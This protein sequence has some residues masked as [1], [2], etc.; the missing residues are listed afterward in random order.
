MENPKK[1]LLFP[2]D[3]ALIIWFCVTLA[4]TIA[5]SVVNAICHGIKFEFFEVVGNWIAV[6]LLFFI[7]S[8]TAKIIG[9]CYAESKEKKERFILIFF[10]FFHSLLILYDMSLFTPLFEY[11]T[12]W[13]FPV[14]SVVLFLLTGIYII[15]LHH[16]WR[17]IVVLLF[18]FPAFLQPLLIMISQQ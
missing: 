10:V 14:L 11:L 6:L 3:I 17:G 15:F 2:E 7:Q 1:K 8:V 9:D 5:L 12:L 4:G 18:A 13:L 16:F